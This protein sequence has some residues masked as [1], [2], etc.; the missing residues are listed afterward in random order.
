MHTADT[1]RDSQI[2]QEISKTNYQNV[3]GTELKGD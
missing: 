3:F 2:L 1:V